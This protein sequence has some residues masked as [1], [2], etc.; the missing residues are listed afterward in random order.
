MR[1][2]PDQLE[3]LFGCEDIPDDL[4]SPLESN[5]YACC[6]LADSGTTVEEVMSSK[7]A[8]SRT[9]AIKAEETQLEAKGVCAIIRKMPPKMKPL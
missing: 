6:M 3:T 1:V 8:D 7:D 5:S 2:A 9:K 4:G